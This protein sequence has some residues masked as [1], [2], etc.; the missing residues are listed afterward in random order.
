MFFVVNPFV[1]HV[2]RHLQSALDFLVEKFKDHRV[3]AVGEQHAA[4]Y[5]ASMTENGCVRMFMRDAC[6]AL[7]DDA[8]ARFRYLVVEFDED[9]M[10]NTLGPWETMTVPPGTVNRKAYWFASYMQSSLALKEVFL[11][12]ARNIPD[13]QLEV[14]GI[15]HRAGNLDIDS[16]DDWLL[17]ND[18]EQRDDE[19]YPEFQAR[20]RETT[21]RRSEELT[22]ASQQRE[23]EATRRFEQRVLARLR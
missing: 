12:I 6:R 20:R 21:S 1:S 22:D 17:G 2:R 11:D 16:S 19:T 23:A 14:V 3:T 9:A 13:S 10:L 4:M 18:L 15:D 8:D 5:L 7:A